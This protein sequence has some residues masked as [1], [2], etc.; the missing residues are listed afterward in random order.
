MAADELDIDPVEIRRKNFIPPDAFPFT[1]VTGLGA[2]YDTGEYAKALDAAL[3]HAGYDDAARRAAGARA[4][5]ATRKLLGIG[6]VVLR[7]DQRAA[8]VQ[9]GVRRGR[10]R[11]RRH[12]DRDASARA[13]TARVTRPRSR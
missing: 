6:V 2:N 5:A 12:G 4:S 3:E 7:R 10:D 11:R 8:G 1:T 9:P 13:R